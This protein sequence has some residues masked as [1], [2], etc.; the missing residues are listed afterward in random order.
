LDALKRFDLEAQRRRETVA[1]DRGETWRAQPSI[2]MVEVVPQPAVQPRL[3]EQP[4][5]QGDCQPVPLARNAV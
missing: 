5:A 3:G 2:E 1:I 4:A